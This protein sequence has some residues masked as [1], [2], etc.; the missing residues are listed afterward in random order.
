MCYPFPTFHIHEKKTPFSVANLTC[1]DQLGDLD[2]QRCP[3]RSLNNF[4]KCKIAW[5][6]STCNEIVKNAEV[7]LF[8]DY[9][10]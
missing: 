7:L 1:V 6:A 4:N 8:I 3:S 9:E 10:E 5:A 2:G